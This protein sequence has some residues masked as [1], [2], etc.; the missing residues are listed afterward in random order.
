MNALLLLP[1]DRVSLTQHARQAIERGPV[2]PGWPVKY[3]PGCPGTVQREE[4]Y[5]VSYLEAPA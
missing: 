1:G 2:A 5:P 4:P 3:S